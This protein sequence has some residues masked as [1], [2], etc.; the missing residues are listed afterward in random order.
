[1][2][3]SNP[4]R[5]SR[6]ETHSDG[7]GADRNSPA[8]ATRR[9][10]SHPSSSIG[11]DLP[12][13]EKPDQTALGILH[14]GM[15]AWVFFPAFQPVGMLLL[16][17]A[18]LNLWRLL[19]WRGGATAAEPLLLVVHLGYGWLVLGTA[20]LDLAVIDAG[21]PQSASIHA[22]LELDRRIMESPLR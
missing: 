19:R 11:V 9:L 8:P 5:N 2:L 13:P 12:I 14:V 21:I 6:L 17:C 16:L 18:A 15:F 10:P 22:L 1:M 20:L 4:P 3:G 7:P